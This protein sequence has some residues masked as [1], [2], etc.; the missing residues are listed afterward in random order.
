MFIIYTGIKP[1]NGSKPKI[2]EFHR[3][4]DESEIAEILSSLMGWK[5]GETIPI[6]GLRSF[7]GTDRTLSDRNSYGFIVRLEI[8]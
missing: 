6:E 2:E 8:K 3:S 1:Y 7:A 5:Y 4:D